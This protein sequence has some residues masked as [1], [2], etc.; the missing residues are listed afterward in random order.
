M[1]YN[2]AHT[3]QNQTTNG[4][5]SNIYYPVPFTV[6]ENTWYRVTCSIT[7][8]GYNVSVNGTNIAHFPFSAIPTSNGAGTWRF[9]VLKGY[10]AYFRDVVVTSENWKL[11]YSN[12]TTSSDIL[13]EYSVDTN[14]QSVCMVRNAEA[15]N[16]CVHSLFYIGWSEKG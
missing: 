6:I 1:V 5:P 3:I 8:V 7:P 16:T 11:L 10:A 12:P 13:S 14:D 15:G 4:V 2:Y 9:G